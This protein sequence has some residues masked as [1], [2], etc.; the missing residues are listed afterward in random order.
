MNFDYFF[1]G[2]I[3]AAAASLPPP[4]L[5]HIPSFWKLPA[6][7]NTDFYWGCQ[8]VSMNWYMRESH[9]L[10]VMVGPE[11]YIISVRPMKD[12]ISELR[13]LGRRGMVSCMDHVVLD[14]SMWGQG[15][16]SYQYMKISRQRDEKR[17]IP[18]NSILTQVQSLLRL[19]QP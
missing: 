2:R 15:E 6:S 10:D 12:P 14:L 9:F 3:V 17:E 5:S 1:Q 13:M 8:S 18:D 4:F 7:R 19:L 11:V 16:T